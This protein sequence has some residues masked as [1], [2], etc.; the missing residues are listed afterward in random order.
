MYLIPW[1]PC[2]ATHSRAKA[3]KG[4][5]DEYGIPLEY[6]DCGGVMLPAEK[7]SGRIIPKEVGGTRYSPVQMATYFFSVLAAGLAGRGEIFSIP[8]LLLHSVDIDLPG[9]FEAVSG[10]W[11]CVVG[12]LA[13]SAIGASYSYY[14]HC[15]AI[16]KWKSLQK[17]DTNSLKEWK[18]QPKNTSSEENKR[19]ARYLG[20][21]NAGFAA[22]LGMATSLMHLHGQHTLL[23]FD[24]SEHG[25]L[26]Y[27]ASFVVFFAWIECFAYM[28]HRFFHLKFI[29]KHFHKMHHRFQPPTSFSAV[30]FHPFEFACYVLGGQAIFFVI[31]IHPSVMLAVGGYTAFYLIEDHSGI[32]QTSPF[33]WQPTTMYHDDHHRY[34]HVNF[35]QHVLWFDWVF[36]TLRKVNRTYGEGCFGGKGGVAMRP[37][38][39]NGDGVRRRVANS[40]E[41]G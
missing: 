13:F 31:P 39:P 11:K 15:S 3:I 2:L 8:I 24:V 40:R 6:Y 37:V 17:S 28:F 21:F 7:E 34:F 4:E 10:E 16:E 41:P 19:F 20:T 5:A 27:L 12:Y 1:L 23:Y 25:I 26:W 38:G 29:Y 33:P 22:I 30:A 35:G 18:C 9:L 36:G 32:R 14:H